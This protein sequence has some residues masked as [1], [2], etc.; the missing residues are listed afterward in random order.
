MEKYWDGELYHE[1]SE[2][3]RAKKIQNKEYSTNLLEKNKISFESKN[4]GNHLIVSGYTVVI[5]FWPSTGKFITRSGYTG[6]GINN[7][8]EFCDWRK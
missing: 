2:K 7:L 8:L 5:D 3:K 6:R 4:N 1:L